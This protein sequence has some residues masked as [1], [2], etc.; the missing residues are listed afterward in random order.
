MNNKKYIDKIIDH[1]VRITNIDY[2]NELVNLPF[3]FHNLPFPF[4]TT[5]Y[6]LLYLLSHQLPESSF[7][8]SFNN[9][10]V[11]TFGLTDDEVRYVLDEYGKII[12]DKIENNG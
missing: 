11:N 10:C 5:H 1:M 8:H 4:H 2:E 6:N 7:Y 9:Y 12:K 3:P